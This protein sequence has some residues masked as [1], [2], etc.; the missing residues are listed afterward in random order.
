MKKIY[1]LLASAA[2]ILAA[3]CNKIEAPIPGG[4]SSDI[5]LNV[6]VSG[7]GGSD[8]KAAKTG[9]VSGDK[10]NIW[11]DDWNNTTKTEN[12][13]PDMIISYDGSA[14]AIS[15]Q[16]EGLSSR[17]KST[18]GKLTAVYEGF[19]DLS[20]YTYQWYSDGEW[21]Y[22][23]SYKHPDANY[24][25]AYHN[26]MVVYKEGNSYSFDGT[27]L[28]ANLDNWNFAT[29][30]KVLIKGSTLL[31]GE[32]YLQVKKAGKDEYA[33]C[34][35]ALVVNTNSNYPMISNGSSN[36]Y[37][38]AGGVQEADGIAFYYSSL[39]ASSEDIEF[40]L[41]NGSTKVATFTATGKTVSCTGS[42]CV[43]IAI[44]YGS[45]TTPIK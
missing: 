37:G 14:W 22:P 12:H 35:G 42:N 16:V 7:F 40:N 2:A 4:S 11:F 43:N 27:T 15:S 10:I 31:A 1:I 33:G 30:F 8:T 24:Q 28:T 45:F 23:A 36:Y 13:V 19:N 9:W 34:K 6:T 21:F 29:Q 20:K 38:F 25:T 39:S 32:S 44:N 26:S 17:L 3:S 5:K 18:D 41:Y